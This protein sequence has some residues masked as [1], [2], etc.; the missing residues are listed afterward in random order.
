MSGSSPEARLGL[1]VDLMEE[2]LRHAGSAE[3]VAALLRQAIIEARDLLLLLPIDPVFESA[4]PTPMILDTAVVRAMGGVLGLLATLL[5]RGGLTTVEEFGKMLDIYAVVTAENCI[6][7]GLI[8]G[9][10]G[11]IVGQVSQQ[12]HEDTA[13]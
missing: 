7:E 6:D 9:C 5:Q 4:G 11:G 3:A 10:W 1:A 12:R 8:V 13:H 2:A